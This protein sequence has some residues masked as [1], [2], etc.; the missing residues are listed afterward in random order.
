MQK[1]EDDEDENTVEEMRLGFK[2]GDKQTNTSASGLHIGMHRSLANL[3]EQRGEK[4]SLLKAIT[5][6]VN[7][8]LDHL[9]KMVQG[10][11]L[12]P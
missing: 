6:L 2:R 4:Q 9:S 1:T 10:S 12:S 8:A 5:D 11:Q 3:Q 7:T